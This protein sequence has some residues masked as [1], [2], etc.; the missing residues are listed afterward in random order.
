[1][2]N[3]TSTPAST[4][5]I[6]SLLPLLLEADNFP[7]FNTPWPTV[8]PLHR[9]RL[10]PFH[11]SIKDFQ[12]GLPPLGIIQRDVLKALRGADGIQFLTVAQEVKGAQKC[13]NG[14]GLCKAD[15]RCGEGEC[16]IMEEEG[17]NG[18]KRKN[19]YKMTTLCVFFSDEVNAKGKEGRTEAMDKVMRKWKEEGKFPEALKLWMDEPFSIYASHKSTAFQTDRCTAGLPFGNIAFEMERA[20]TSLFGCQALGVHL[21]GTAYEGSGDEMKIWA[22]RRS[23]NRYRSPLK[24]DS[25]VAGG[26]PAGLTPMQGLIKECEEEAGWPEEMVRKYAKNVGMVTHFELTDSGFLAPAADYTF[27]L[28]LPPRSDPSYVLPNP[29]DDEVDSFTLLPVQEIIQALHDGEFKPSSALV[30]I[31]FLLRH[32]FVTPENEP[33]FAEVSRRCHRWNGVAGPGYSSVT[34]VVISLGK[35]CGFVSFSVPGD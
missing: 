15:G 26:L 8:H 22:P 23:A 20:G 3:P 35:H 27:D 2:T 10:I 9:S 18:E 25:S 6:K 24:Y 33:N 32:G 12:R 17:K 13:K 16:R 4:K 1:M 11:V 29:N 31:D 7:I 28:P 30:T 34:D 21:T 14:K 5:A 19:V